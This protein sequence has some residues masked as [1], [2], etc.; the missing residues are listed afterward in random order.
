MQT[1][2]LP[3]TLAELWEGAAQY[4]MHVHDGR[5]QFHARETML[6]RAQHYFYLTL[7][8]IHRYSPKHNFMDE[9][10]TSRLTGASSVSIGV[11]YKDILPLARLWSRNVNHIRWEDRLRFD[12][13]HPF[14]PF[15]H[16]VIWDSTCMRVQRA[17]QWQYS[18]F[19][20]NGHYDFPCFLVLIG[21]TLT[22]DLVFGSDLF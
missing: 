7:C 21:I 8:Y 17:T 9:I 19:V 22:G 11:F 20:V 13:H 5:G 4:F 12:N 14:F 10:Q 18:R 3:A 6:W 16:T 2:Y 1:G 15:S